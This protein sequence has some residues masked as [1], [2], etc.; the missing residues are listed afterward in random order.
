MAVG[1]LEQMLLILQATVLAVLL[2]ACANVANLQ[3][4]RIVARRKELSVRS[5]LG[6]SRG[7][8][9]RLVL[10]ESFVLGILG[11]L[12]GLLLTRLGLGLVSGLGLDRVGQG[13]QFVMDSTVIGFTAGATYYC[14]RCQR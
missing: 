9:V 11:G 6:A 12:G 2:I 8:L 7:R 13:F 4:A 1:D 14:K 5:A 10:V 3:L